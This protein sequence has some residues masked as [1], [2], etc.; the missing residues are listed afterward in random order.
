VAARQGIVAELLRVL[1]E[2]RQ[3]VVELA[4]EQILAVIHARDFRLTDLCHAGIMLRFYP[5]FA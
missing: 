2:V 1:G 3:R 5:D 4:T